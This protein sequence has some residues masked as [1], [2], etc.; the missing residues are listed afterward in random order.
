VNCSLLTNTPLDLVI[1]VNYLTV[2]SDQFA[3]SKP[4]R[5]C[6]DISAV[7]VYRTINRGDLV[8]YITTHYKGPRIVLA[9]AGGRFYRLKE[10]HHNICENG[11]LM[12]C[13]KRCFQWHQPISRKCLHNWSKSHNVH[14]HWQI[15]QNIFQWF[16]CCLL[17]R[18]FTQWIDRFGQIPLWESSCQIQGRG[19]NFPTMWLY[20]KWGEIEGP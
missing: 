16:C 17:N 13:S 14:C 6:S 7:C 15:A 11:M 12:F 9:A 20:W 8:E 1:P 2:I 18:G 5:I 19:A 4:Q 3:S 10:H